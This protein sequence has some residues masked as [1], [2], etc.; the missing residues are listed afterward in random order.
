MSGI[1][2]FQT[3]RNWKSLFIPAQAFHIVG[4]GLLNAVPPTLQDVQVAL[5]SVTDSTY[6]NALS[7]VSTVKHVGFKMNTN[8]DTVNTLLPT[9]QDRDV[10]EPMYARVIWTTGS[11]TTA[12]TITWKMFI[13]TLSLNS[14][15]LSGTINTAL[16]TPIPQDTVPT[17]TAYTLNATAKGTINAN[18]APV[19]TRDSTYM[20]LQIEMHAKAVGLSEDVFFM[21][22][23]LLYAP[24]LLGTAYGQGNLPALPTSWQ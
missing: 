10:M 16:N 19:A 12:D 22:V 15:A 4:A 13:R 17:T 18:S 20:S 24:H 8:G 3:A 2:D 5:G 14:T 23:E 9:I 7:Q 6:A 1:N 21:G 11:V